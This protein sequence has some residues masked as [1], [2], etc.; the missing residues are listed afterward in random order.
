MTL[1]AYARALAVG[2]VAVLCMATPAWPA[3][4]AVT[5]C[6][7]V[8]RGRGFLTAD[9][10]CTGFIGHAVTIERGKLE[11]R[12]FTIRGAVFYG[13]HCEAACQINGPGAITANGLD[14]V[15]AA[16]WAIVR[17][18]RVTDNG[19]SGVSARNINGG[20]RLLIKDSTIT[21]NGF[22]GI[23]TDNL[24]RV[25]GSLISGNAQ[26]GVDVGVQ[27]CDSGGRTTLTRSTVSGNSTA[28][29]GPTACADL[30]TCGRRNAPPRLGK[31]S[32]CG[33]SYVRGSGIPGTSW[34]VCS[35]D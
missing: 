15:N 22:N 16:H 14:G 5:Y 35:N 12:G 4:T 29:V 9:L 32:S 19:L 7:Q 27:H 10:D 13:V 2:S 25:R 30:T 6:G 18:T 23:E 31:G 17:D 24:A 26:N 21:G 3:T 33:I 28:C 8:I 34:G 11:L 20:S 1:R